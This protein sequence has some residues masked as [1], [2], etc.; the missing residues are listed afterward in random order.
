M[1]LFDRN[2]QDSHIAVNDELHQAEARGTPVGSGGGKRGGEW[3]R[4]LRGRGSTIAIQN[5]DEQALPIESGYLETHPTSIPHGG[6]GRDP[7]GWPKVIPVGVPPSVSGEP[8]RE[9]VPKE[10]RIPAIPGNF[11][12]YI[13]VLGGATGELL[14]EPISF[15]ART[16]QIDN[17][18]SCFIYVYGAERYIPPATIGWQFVL[19][20]GVTTIRCTG[21]A[22][23]N[24][25]Q[26][27]FTAG[28]VFYVF[29]FEAALSPNSVGGA[30]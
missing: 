4:R 29:C 15:P 14:A 6:R 16:I 22:P 30:A 3:A 20:R 2:N 24:F 10:Y 11:S 17:Y 27:A 25:A 23:P 12:S 1:T 28:G 21:A 5:A 19:G 18:T 7:G 9:A 26:P 8:R 13:A